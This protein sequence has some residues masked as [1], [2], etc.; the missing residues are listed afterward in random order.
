MP[1][2]IKE[3]TVEEIGNIWLNQGT[4][5]ANDLPLRTPYQLH[6]LPKLMQATLC[7]QRY[8]PN[9]ERRLTFAIEEGHF[10]RRMG[11]LAT[12]IEAKVALNIAL[13]QIKKLP[14][15]ESRKTLAHYHLCWVNYNLG[16]FAMA[17]VH[18]VG[19]AQCSS[20]YQLSSSADNAFFITLDAYVGASDRTT[21]YYHRFIQKAYS[22]VYD[23]ESPTEEANRIYQRCVLAS[24]IPNIVDSNL[25]KDVLNKLLARTLN[26]NIDHNAFADVAHVCLAYLLLEEGKTEQAYSLLE[27]GTAGNIIDASA[28]ALFIKLKATILLGMKE[29]K[30]KLIQLINDFN[31]GLGGHIFK[32][33]AYRL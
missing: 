8:A 21:I 16:E 7:A 26:G 27:V 5:D 32:I 33:A 12:N 6:N 15:T 31:G 30:E 14:N 4:V 19:T 11:T 29:E 10:L 18:A 20:K 23:L 1:K 25:Q 3:I 28:F 24:I 22:A 17:S 2:T 9:C 13:E